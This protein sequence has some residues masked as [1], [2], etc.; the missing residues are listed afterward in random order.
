MLSY[1]YY[2]ILHYFHPKYSS[3]NVIKIIIF[4]LYRQNFSTEKEMIC[5]QYTI[6]FDYFCDDN[7]AY[8]RSHCGVHLLQKKGPFQRKLTFHVGD[9]DKRS[10]LCFVEV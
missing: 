7:S 4:I 8:T 9:A 10:F 3:L 2:K 6:C 1:Y 5:P